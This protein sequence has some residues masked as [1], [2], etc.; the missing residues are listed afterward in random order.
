MAE[1]S[2]QPK[3]FLSKP[4]SVS[5]TVSLRRLI[6]PSFSYPR[7]VGFSSGFDC[8]PAISLTNAFTRRAA[9]SKFGG[10]W[11]H[12]PQRKHFRPSIPVNYLGQSG[13]NGRQ[14]QPHPGGGAAILLSSAGAP[15][16]S[17]CP[18]RSFSPIPGKNSEEHR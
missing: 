12:M 17:P 3:G 18:N 1:P 2:L 15:D 6:L 14:A 11:R 13:D 4:E 10:D 8:S 16:W 5:T 7:G 9:L